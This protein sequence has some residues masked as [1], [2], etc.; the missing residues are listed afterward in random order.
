MMGSG[1]QIAFLFPKVLTINQIYPCLDN[2]LFPSNV[3][4]L[5]LISIMQMKHCSEMH[6]LPSVFLS[7]IM[8]VKT[9]P[10]LIFNTHQS[11]VSSDTSVEGRKLSYSAALKLPGLNLYGLSTMERFRLK[12]LLTKKPQVCC[13]EETTK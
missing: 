12:C 3:W 1:S 4:D 13:G 2:S 9:K 5:Y 10:E 11:N 7:L 6:V 8:N